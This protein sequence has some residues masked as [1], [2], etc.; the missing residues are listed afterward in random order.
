MPTEYNNILEI[1]KQRLEPIL[2]E[3]NADL[4]EST[5]KRASKKLIL[6]L[7]IDKEGGIKINIVMNI[8][9]LATFMVPS[10]LFYRSNVELYH[11]LFAILLFDFLVAHQLH[12]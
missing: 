2:N 10:Y 3:L 6:R 11:M 7:L 1:L 8:T 5:L 4:I 12:E 9:I